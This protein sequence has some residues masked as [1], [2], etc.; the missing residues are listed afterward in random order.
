MICRYLPFG[1]NEFLHELDSYVAEKIEIDGSDLKTKLQQLKSK[2]SGINV[3]NN[4][5]GCQGSSSNLRGYSCGLWELFHFLTVQA[6]ADPTLSDPLVSL[7]TVHGFVKNFFGCTDCSQHFQAMANELFIWQVSS[8]DDAV[9]WLWKAHNQVNRRLAGDETEDPAF[10]KIQFPSQTICVRCR[11]EFLNWQTNEV[12]HFLKEYYGVGN[13]SRADGLEMDLPRAEKRILDNVFSEMDMRM[14][15]VL[16]VFCIGMMVVA[17]KL[18]VRRG[19][20]R[21]SY[22]YDF[23]V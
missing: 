21:K 4:W 19:Y 7:K 6:A 2:W 13:I 23:K 1:D 18:L 8:K 5:I 10:P 16:Y 20:R 14:G 15:I 12:L 17:V 11:D 9:L 22:S 3:T